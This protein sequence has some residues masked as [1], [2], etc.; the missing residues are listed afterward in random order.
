MGTLNAKCRL[1]ARS[2]NLT[3]GRRGQEG[4]VK[5]LPS[6]C[7]QKSFNSKI[8]WNSITRIKKISHLR[9]GRKFI[10]KD[11]YEGLSKSS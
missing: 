2:L 9:H 11:V 6:P 1:M 3:F 7:V 10:K 5:E 8:K 4:D